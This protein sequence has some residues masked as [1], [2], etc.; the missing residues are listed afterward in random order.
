MLA[1]VVQ[2]ADR[3]IYV[4]SLTVCAGTESKDTWDFHLMSERTFLGSCKDVETYISDRKPGLVGV[5]ESY[6]PAVHI[7]ACSTH[8]LDNLEKSKHKLSKDALI[9]WHKLKSAR[10]EKDAEK[11][12][13]L[14]E[15]Q[16][17][18]EGSEYF[19]NSMWDSDVINKVN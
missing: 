19:L 13:K 11:L 14:F 9:T 7:G 8:L 12:L 4:K 15:E 3:E 16:A 1:S 6:Q 18:Q 5:I 10:N 2:G 17:G